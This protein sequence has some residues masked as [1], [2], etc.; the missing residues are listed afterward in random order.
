M[1]QFLVESAVICLLGGLLGL[2]ISYPLSLII[3]QV[4]P[5]AMPISVAVVGLLV[6]LAVGVVSSTLALDTQFLVLATMFSHDIVMHYF[7]QERFD[8]RKQILLGRIFV[9]VI[10]VIAMFVPQIRQYNEL[11]RRETALQDEIRLEEEILKHLQKQQKLLSEDPRFVEKIA[12]EELGYAKPGETVFRFTD[13]DVPSS[14]RPS[15]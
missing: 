5:T 10:A 13:D 7:G 4:L 11:H 6:S 1:V 9:V 14:N 15:R 2:M 8:D 3:D 12:R